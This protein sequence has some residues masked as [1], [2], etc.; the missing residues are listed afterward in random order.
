MCLVNAISVNC[1]FTKNILLNEKYSFFNQLKI[2]TGVILP[3][4]VMNGE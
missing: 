2:G 1:Y 3:A 4:T